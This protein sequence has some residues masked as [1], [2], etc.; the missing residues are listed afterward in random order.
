MKKSDVQVCVGAHLRRIDSF[1]TQRKAQGPSR[2]CNESKEE[3]KVRGSLRTRTDA[4]PHPP[5][6]CDQLVVFETSGLHCRSL[7]SGGLRCKSRGAR[8]RIWSPSEGW[9][10]RWC[11][12]YDVGGADRIHA[13]NARKSGWHGAQ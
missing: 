1:I 5:Y 11:E 4:C 12:Q 8:K 3:E 6:E 13:G 9:W 2:T 10:A 7:D